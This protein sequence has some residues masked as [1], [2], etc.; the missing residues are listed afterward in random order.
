MITHDPFQTYATLGSYYGIP[1]P[2]GLQPSLQTSAIN[3]VAALNP[4]LGLSPIAQTVGIPQFVQSPYGLNPVQSL[5]NPSPILQS[6]LLQ[7]PLLA[8]SLLSNPLIAAS[9]QS[10]ALAY[11]VPQLGFQQPSLYPQIGQ[12][13]S[14]FG[15]IPSPFSQIG[16]PFGQIGYPLAPQSWIGQGGGQMFG[17]VH[18]FQSQLSP[19]PLFQGQGLSPWGY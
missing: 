9:L 14:P 10:Q 8:A 17:Q 4:L 6:A 19:R 15:Q 13:G 18:P 1:T 7:N 3:P 12:L 16:S 2:I 11:G 5:I